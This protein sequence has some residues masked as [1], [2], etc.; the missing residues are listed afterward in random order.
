LN[1]GTALWLASSGK[2][3]VRSCPASEVAT[4]KSLALEQESGQNSNNVLREA[5]EGSSEEAIEG[6]G[7]EGEN[8]YES[9]ARVLL[10]G[11]GADEQCGGYGRHRTKFRLGGLV[12]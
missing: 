1:I 3:N 9:E 10:V 8:Y 12:Y 11:S 2:G 4:Q 6:G 5:P 7:T